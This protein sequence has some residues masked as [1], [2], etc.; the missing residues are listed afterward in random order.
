MSFEPYDVTALLKEVQNNGKHLESEEGR[1]RCF[2]AAASLVRALETPREAVMR[3]LYA[4]V[5]AP[6]YQISCG[7][8]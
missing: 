8:L 3:L 7:I 1:R 4:E 2:E 5:Y 6:L